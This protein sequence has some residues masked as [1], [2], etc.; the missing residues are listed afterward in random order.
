MELIAQYGHIWLVVLPLVFLGGGC[1]FGCGGRRTD[2]SARL[3]DGTAAACN[4][5]DPI[6]LQRALAR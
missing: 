3:Y 2:Y 5:A 1:G 4:G 6:N